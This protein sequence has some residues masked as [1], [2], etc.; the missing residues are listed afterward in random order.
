MSDS[1]ENFLGSGSDVE[2]EDIPKQKI[3]PSRPPLY[4]SSSSE[5]SVGEPE[6]PAHV[7]L[8]QNTASSSQN[9]DLMIELGL[10]SSEDDNDKV[11]K[12]TDNAIDSTKDSS[13]LFNSSDDES[14]DSPHYS[15]FEAGD[16]SANA[17]LNSTSQALFGEELSSSSSDD[18][19]SN[20]GSRTEPSGVKNRELLGL[21]STGESEDLGSGDEG[22]VSK[23]EILEEHVVDDNNDEFLDEVEGG[24]GSDQNEAVGFLS[25]DDDDDDI[26]GADASHD[27]HANLSAQMPKSSLEMGSE[28]FYV[29]LP[30]FLSIDTRP[31][32]P[33]YYEY[34]G[35]DE[36]I[37]D[38]EGRK[39]LKL[40]VEN[41]IRW[42]KTKDQ[43]GQEIR[44]SNARIVKWKNG[45]LSL[46]LGNE[47]FDVSQL[48]MEDKCN[49]LYLVQNAFLQAQSVFNKKLNIKPSSTDS[50]THRKITLSIAD[51]VSRTQKM[52]MIPAAGENPEVI[53][54]ALQVKQEAR[55]KAEKLRIS[56]ERARKRKLLFSG[57]KL[58]RKY[59]EDDEELSDDSTSV[60]AVKKKFQQARKAAKTKRKHSIDDFIVD[61]DEKEI[62]KSSDS[63]HDELTS[64]SEP[65]KE[66]S[67][68]TDASVGTRKR[69]NSFKSANFG[70]KKK[71]VIHDSDSSLDISS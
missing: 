15:D 25:D 26:L 31:F 2:Q 6:N 40:K 14:V 34:E 32:N 67:D 16:V 23:Q 56:K 49:H 19:S 55:A 46:Y 59:L 21:E 17:T 51:R 66:D 12:N 33:S 54:A 18:G 47:I 11:Q 35:D 61:S 68:E 57:Q 48:K 39:R 7:N 45:T 38:E 37:L 20:G 65:E 4:L 27:T 29:K 44:E 10:S 22:A 53:R 52:R 8:S 42:R 13:R 62:Y 69:Q 28:I 43:T 58:S 50:Q 41:T 24:G 1:S 9:R 3:P 71:K 70:T 36:E 60:N 30:N 64:S 5:G 63:E